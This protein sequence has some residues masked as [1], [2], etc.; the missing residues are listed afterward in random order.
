MLRKQRVGDSGLNVDDTAASLSHGE[1]SVSVGADGTT[2]TGDLNVTG[3]LTSTVKRSAV[4]T[5]LTRQMWQA[6]FLILK[7]KSAQALTAR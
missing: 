4:M 1:N 2:V 7:S 6:M 3:D 5:W